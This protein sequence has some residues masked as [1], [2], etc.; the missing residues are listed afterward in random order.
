MPDGEE[1]I[2]N[3]LSNRRPIDDVF[4]EHVH[5]HTRIF[6]ENLSPFV[7]QLVENL[8]SEGI[9]GGKVL[10][11]MAGEAAQDMEVP[12]AHESAMAGILLA[13]E[14]VIGALQ[15]R[16]EVLAPVT[17]LNLSDQI[18]PYLQEEL[19]KHYTGRCICQDEVFINCY[20]EKWYAT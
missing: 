19:D 14:I 13:A 9:C 12:M 2:H 20:K 17:S 1:F 15:L 10:S 8:Y 18:H 4:V 11:V 6:K 16:H 7:G 3:Y 5:A